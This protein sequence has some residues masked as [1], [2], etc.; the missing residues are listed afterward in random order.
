MSIYADKVDGKLTGRFCVEVTINGKRLRGR[1]DTIEAA[2]VKEAEFELHL[3]TGEAP[4]AKDNHNRNSRPL[5]LSHLLEKA[6][7]L[8]WNGSAH[9][10]DCER[11]VRAMVSRFNDPRLERVDT[12]FVDDV[13]LWLRAEGRS[14]ATINRYFAA[15]HAI[16]K[17]AAAPG[18]KYIAEMPV[19]DWQEEDEGRV[20]SV[21][22][23]E[24]AQ[25]EEFLFFHDQREI[26]DFVTVAIDTGCRR[27]ELLAAR[28]EQL[29][30]NWL[31]LWSDQTKGKVSR[32][33][34]LTPRAMALLAKRLPWKLTTR[35]LEYWWGEAREAIGLDTDDDFVLHA[36]RHTC[37]TRLVE[38][39]INLAVVQ[40]FMGHKS[41]QTTLRYAHVS[42]ELLSQ[43]AVAL[44]RGPLV[45]VCGVS[46]VSP[47]D[48]VSVG[49]N[50]AA[51]PH[52]ARTA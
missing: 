46:G 24:E 27:G 17:W 50:G 7:P 20:R 16:L 6:A 5:T 32:S 52:L 39:G 43:A 29:D 10:Q 31:R 41:I 36:C 12:T 51:L 33:V 28:A 25:L 40:K 45:S 47:G 11:K 13:I 42:D 14:P 9:G 37:A 4:A 15:L 2:K 48:V 1:C 49:E 34:P 38:R 35:A 26:A 30:G 22:L 44:A 21:S 8:L 18:R 23:Y 19:F 3:R